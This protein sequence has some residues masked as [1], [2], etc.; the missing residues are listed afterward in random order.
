MGDAHRRPALET[1]S[2]SGIRGGRQD[3]DARPRATG[4]RPAAGVEIGH[5]GKEL[6][7]ADER[8]GSGHGG[9]SIR[10]C[11]RHDRRAPPTC[12]S[13]RPSMT[14]RQRWTLVATIIGSGAVFLDGTIVN[15]G[16]QAHRPGAAGHRSIGVLEGQTYVVSGYLAVLAALLILAG[17]L[18]D[19]YGRRRVYAIGLV[20][21]AATSALCGLAPTLEWLVVFRLAPGRRRARCSSRAR[22]PSSPTP[23]TAPQRGRAFGIWAAATSGADV[24]RAARRRDPRRHRRLARRVPRSTS[25]CS[26]RAVGDASATSPSRAT[27]RRPGGSTGSARSSRPWPSA[28]WRSGSSAARPTSGRTR[29]PGSRSRSASSPSIAFPILMARR[30]RPARPARAV[31]VAGVR[32]D[33]P[34]DVLHLRRRCTSRSS[35]R[36]SSCRASSATR[37]SPPASSGMPSGHLLALLSTRIGTLA[38]RIGPRRVPRRRAAA[39]GG[40]AAVVRPPAGRLG[41]VAGVDRR[42]RRASSRRSSVFVDV[43]PASSCSGSGSR[44]SSRR[45]RPR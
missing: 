43:L 10:R 35:T 40:R 38:G 13:P 42:T 9:E 44:A 14:S 31:P 1:S 25:R 32:L 6:T 16:A 2:P 41:A 20:G 17:A 4:R 27:P 11:P 39:H 30:P 45:S 15:V 19:H 8:H 29:S 3:R 18:S 33:Q 36:R 7:G 37:R 12:G 22:W 5:R 26:R 23:S 34:R 24:A 21:F 28:A